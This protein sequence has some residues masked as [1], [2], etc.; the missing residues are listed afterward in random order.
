M[1]ALVVKLANETGQDPEK[2]AAELDQAIDAGL[3]E[4]TPDGLRI[5]IPG[6]GER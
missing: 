1:V 3:L 2:V 6:E 5:A 4:L